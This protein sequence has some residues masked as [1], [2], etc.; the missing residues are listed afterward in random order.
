[1]NSTRFTD[2]PVLGKHNTPPTQKPGTFR[3]TGKKLDPI[4]WVLMAVAT[5][6]V[7][8]FEK[9]PGSQSLAPVWAL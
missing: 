7:E 5:L 6:L 8:I 3:E 4:A 1:M 2:I 9:E